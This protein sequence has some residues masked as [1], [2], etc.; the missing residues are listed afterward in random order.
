ML[1][2]PSWLSVMGGCQGIT[3]AGAGNVG[4]GTCVLLALCLLPVRV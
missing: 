3:V 4:S 2:S 1:E